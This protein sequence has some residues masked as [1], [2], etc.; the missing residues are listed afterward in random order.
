MSSLDKAKEEAKKLA[1]QMR[2]GAE[3][4]RQDTIHQ[5]RTDRVSY[6]ILASVLPFVFLLANAYVQGNRWYKKVDGRHDFHQLSSNAPPAA[7]FQYG[8]GLFGG[9][10]LALLVHFVSPT[11]NTVFG[12]MLYGLFNYLSILTG[13][14][15]S[16]VEVYEAL[17]SKNH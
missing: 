14:A 16:A 3:R 15:C 11:I 10:G 4:L 17:K 6:G 12:S 13:G 1:D 5:L 7:K 8:L 2:D 9:V